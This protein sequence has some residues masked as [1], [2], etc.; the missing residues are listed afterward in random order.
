V[1][2]LVRGLVALTP[3]LAAGRGAG[4]YG[5]VAEQLAGLIAGTTEPAELTTLADALAMVVA[6]LDERA[7][8]AYCGPAG[9]ALIRALP[10][11]LH[12]SQ[13]QGLAQG[14]ATILAPG[15]TAGQPRLVALGGTV[16]ALTDP[17]LLFAA[18]VLL[19]PILEPLPPRL[20]PRSLV[21]LLEHPLSVG[22]ARRVVLNQLARHH[23][24]PFADQWDFAR[25][26][27]GR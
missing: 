23:G 18:P 16:A 11:I 22:S 27:Q 14:L 5:P 2:S 1:R 21:A 26:A 17:A 4:L 12:P 24:R 3:H 9:E 10:R 15:A 13:G 19:H 25:F 6:R 7:A 20:P 8:V